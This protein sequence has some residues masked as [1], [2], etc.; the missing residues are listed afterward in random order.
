MFLPESSEYLLPEVLFLPVFHFSHSKN[1]KSPYT[2]F[3][4]CIGKLENR[5]A[6]ITVN[7]EINEN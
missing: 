7:K 4:K 2:S 1:S 3:F 6:R 5:P